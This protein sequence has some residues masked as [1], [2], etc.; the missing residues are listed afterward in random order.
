MGRL[1][2]TSLQELDLARIALFRGGPNKHDLAVDLVL[3]HDVAEGEERAEASDS[4]EVVPTRMADI[5][6]SVH[7]RVEA[8]RARRLAIG[9][10]CPPG[11]RHALVRIVVYLEP[12]VLEELCKLRARL[13]FLPCQLRVLVQIVRDGCQVGTL[14][15]QECLNVLPRLGSAYSKKVGRSP[16][17]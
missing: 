16:L 7:L 8:E 4:N 10:L 11:G 5:R 6:E 9:V 13:D 3:L 14:P 17:A 15:V 2:C 12:L 1:T